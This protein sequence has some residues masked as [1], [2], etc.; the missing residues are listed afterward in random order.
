MVRVARIKG[1]FRR[2]ARGPCPPRCQVNIIVKTVHHVTCT[3]TKRYVVITYNQ[4]ASD[5][6]ASIQLQQQY[7]SVHNKALIAL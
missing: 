1:G 3:C 7:F 2:G 6:I 4:I 5:I